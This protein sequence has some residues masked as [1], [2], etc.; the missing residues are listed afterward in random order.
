MFDKYINGIKVRYYRLPKLDKSAKLVPG[1]IFY[2]GGGFAFGDIGMFLL[3]S[4][5]WK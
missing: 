3:V 1:L 2:H 4:L 5:S